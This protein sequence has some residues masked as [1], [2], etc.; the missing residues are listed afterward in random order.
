[1]FHDY[2][3]IQCRL[4][5]TFKNIVWKKYLLW[6]LLPWRRTSRLTAQIFTSAQDDIGY[7]PLTPS[8]KSS[9]ILNPH[10]AAKPTPYTQQHYSS[11]Q[12]LHILT[13][14]LPFAL[15][16]ISYIPFL[17]LSVMPSMQEKVDIICP[18][19]WMVIDP[20]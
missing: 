13:K 15:L 7:P 8:R 6:T 14:P 11:Q 17:T 2:C 16:V 20:S 19:E 3:E 9:L 5:I 4:K 1:M 10:S 18:L 12:L